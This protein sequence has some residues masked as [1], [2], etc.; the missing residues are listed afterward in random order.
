[1][2]KYF[3]TDG[4]RGEANKNLTF[5]HAVKI[6]RFLGWY[7]GENMGK[8]AK[9]VIGKDTRRSS[10]MFESA[11]AIAIS[12]FLTSECYYLAGSYTHSLD[13]LNNIL[14]LCPVGSDILHG[15]SSHIARNQREVLHPI[16]SGLDASGHHIIPYLTASAYHSAVIIDSIALDA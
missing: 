14:C 2:G 10:Y 16:V 9:I 15:R 5:E 13:T 1:M 8:K 3:G 11:L 7:F 6:G 12:T 4:F